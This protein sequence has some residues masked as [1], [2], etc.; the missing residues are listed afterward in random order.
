LKSGGADVSRSLDVDAKRLAPRLGDHA[1][2]G[3]RVKN[4]RHAV[5]D[6]ADQRR[7]AN[8]AD[9]KFDIRDALPLGAARRT[10]EQSADAKA[11]LAQRPHQIGA[12]KS[13]GARHQHAPGANGLFATHRRSPFQPQFRATLTIEG[14]RRKM[15]WDNA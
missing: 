5:E 1:R 9:Y 15:P 14:R 10:A 2:Q 3:R 11:V 8:V 13:A 6:T 4:A 7:I 12:E